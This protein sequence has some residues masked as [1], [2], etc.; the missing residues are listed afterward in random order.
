M[1]HNSCDLVLQQSEVPCFRNYH[2]SLDRP[3]EKSRKKNKHIW[4]VS[5]QSTNL[6]TWALRLWLAAKITWSSQKKTP[7]G[8]TEAAMMQSEQHVV[9][10]LPIRDGTKCSICVGIFVV[11]SS[12]SNSRLMLNILQG[13]FT[14]HKRRVDRF[15][16]GFSELKWNQPSADD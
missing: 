16:K 6:G 13:G 10:W 5:Q 9:R 11:F 4:T 15:K 14:T 12:D 8:S 1:S 2:I 7:R 3:C